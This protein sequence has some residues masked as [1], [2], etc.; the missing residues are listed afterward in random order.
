[1]QFGTQRFA[2]YNIRCCTARYVYVNTGEIVLYFD[3]YSVIWRCTR[4]SR[5]SF[6]AQTFLGVLGRK[7][8]V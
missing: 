6:T 5:R 8:G 2:H 4:F 7:I 3:W 1:M